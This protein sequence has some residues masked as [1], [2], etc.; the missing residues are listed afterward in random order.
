MKKFKYIHGDGGLVMIKAPTLF[1]LHYYTLT[2]LI[3]FPQK[4]PMDQLVTTCLLLT[5]L[6]F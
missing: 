4:M 3:L 1:Y 6:L 2:F 5:V